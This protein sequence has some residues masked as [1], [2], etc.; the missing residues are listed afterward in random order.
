[1]DPVFELSIKPEDREAIRASLREYN[2]ANA[3]FRGPY[4]EVSSVLRNRDG[5][6]EGGLTGESFYSWLFIEYLFVPEHRRG[7]GLGTKMMMQAEDYARSLCLT[8]I[9]LDTF[10][11]QALPFYEK[12]GYRQFGTIDN[13]PPGGA[14]H[15][16]SKTLTA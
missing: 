3:G 4:N 11:F 8:G 1:M 12:L 2:M 13:F 14:R 6:I 15:F 5:D 7:Q 16:L 9:W 10:S